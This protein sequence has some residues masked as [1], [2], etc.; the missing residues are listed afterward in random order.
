MNVEWATVLMVTGCLIAFVVAVLRLE[1]AEWP[2]YVAGFI[3]FVLFIVLINASIMSVARR[4]CRVI[5]ELNGWDHQYS[6]TNKCL[7]EVE[8]GRWIPKSAIYSQV[9]DLPS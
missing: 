4:S 2:G 5:G 8:P 1:H 6:Y 3:L 7:L 9:E